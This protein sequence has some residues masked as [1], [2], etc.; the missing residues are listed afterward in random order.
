[1]NNSEYLGLVSI[2]I[3]VYN[4]EK[5]LTQCL[6]SLVDQSYSDWECIIVNDCSTDQSE[7][8]INRFLANFPEKF[9][10]LK[11]TSNIKAGPSRNHGVQL[12]KGEYICFVDGDDFLPLNALEL[13][14]ANSTKNPEII[15]GN[16]YVSE[17]H[18]SK[19]KLI[20]PD[21]VSDYNFSKYKVFASPW[22]KLFRRDFWQQNNFLFDN[23]F[24][25][26]V[27]LITQIL[28]IANNVNITNDCV[29]CYRENPKSV[30]KKMYPVSVFIYILNQLADFFVSH[31]L[32]NDETKCVL[33]SNFY[34]FSKNIARSTERYRLYKFIVTI[35]PD[36]PEKSSYFN[37][38]LVPLHEQQKL[39][40]IYK[41]KGI[42]F[43][44]RPSFKSLSNAFARMRVFP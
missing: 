27:L 17:A 19:L 39:K 13:F 21:I 25:E 22:A 31:S 1:M 10:Y 26:D 14:F 37:P 9:T 20:T 42:Y 5:Y 29:Y 23:V 40:R 15:I 3:P 33:L 11:N 8:I 38:P 6:Q 24:G 18:N 30:T 36:L 2:I 28:A 16:F 35:I 32:W 44:L 41:S 7:L 43:L 4:V 12:A 34:L